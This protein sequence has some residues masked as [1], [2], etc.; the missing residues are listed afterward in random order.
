MSKEL[1]L[2]RDFWNPVIEKIAGNLTTMTDS[3]GHNRKGGNILSASIVS[4]NIDKLATEAIDYYRVLIEIPDY[5]VY[6]DQGVSGWANERKT[7]D[8]FSFKRSGGRIPLKSIRSFML[9]RQ[10]VPRDA[11]GNRTRPKNYEKALD[12]LA[13]IIGSSIKKKGIEMVPFYSSVL[14]DELI[15]TF[16][17]KM[18]DIMGDRLADDL[19]EGL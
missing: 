3:R 10:I 19:T 17:S 16:T 14:T 13:Y 1:E 15:N 7:T 9:N 4:D 11:K 18:L 2:I 12:N 8:R 6:I 5:G